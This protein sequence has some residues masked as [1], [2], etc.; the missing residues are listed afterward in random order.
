MTI[1]KGYETV[2][3]ID[4][5]A[6][7]GTAVS[8][9]AADKG[10]KLLTE[11]IAVTP[12]Y[13]PNES[14]CGSRF[15]RSSDVGRIDVAGSFETYAQ[16]ANGN[17]FTLIGMAM[18]R[19]GIPT[20]ING[21]PLANRPYPYYGRFQLRDNLE[22]YFITMALDKQ[23]AI[24]EIDTMKIS[25]MTISGEAGDR[26]K[27]AFEGIGHRWRNDSAVNTTLASVSEPTPRKYI[28]FQ[29]GQFRVSA[30]ANAAMDGDNQIYPSAFSIT[31]N[32]T[33]DPILTAKNDPY[34]DEP[35]AN[36]WGEV[37]GSFTI[38]KYTTTVYENAFIAG[39]IMKADIRFISTTQINT[40]GGGPYYYEFNL[41]MPQIQITEAN[42]PLEGAGRI[43]QNIN[44]I[45]TK[46]DAAPDG[47]DGSGALSDDGEARNSITLPLEIEYKSV[48]QADPLG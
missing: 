28:M 41:F 15:P 32:N 27:L 14:I 29:E 21:V 13:L 4:K 7:W 3:A 42:A 25:Q 8:V 40:A 20:A 18:G 2:V 5:A 22:G 30:Q 34:V 10:V 23:V 44:F 17:I 39:T 45:A 24:H 11:S 43:S 33:M 16:Y 48:V 47:M 37:T 19:A 12:N 31:L 38:P 9:N 35:V 1:A 46:A 6:T 36:G 26:V